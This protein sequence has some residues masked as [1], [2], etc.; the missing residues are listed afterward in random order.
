MTMFYEYSLSSS[1]PRGKGT[2]ANAG[3]LW[4]FYVNKALAKSVQYSKA[5][6][7]IKTNA[8]LVGSISLD[9]ISQRRGLYSLTPGSIGLWALTPAHFPD[10]DFPKS[11]LAPFELE[12]KQS[13]NYFCEARYVKHF[14]S[15]T[16]PFGDILDDYGPL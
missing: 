3:R 2:R 13:P 10:L 9:P 1:S 8:N 6:F 12:L 16:P 14:M 4:F 7:V 15:N 5:T 11:A